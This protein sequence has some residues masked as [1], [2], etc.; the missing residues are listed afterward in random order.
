[1]VWYKNALF[2]EIT[3]KTFAFQVPSGG[4]DR[5]ASFPGLQGQDFTITGI[6]WKES[7]ADIVLSNVGWVSITAGQQADVQITAYTP[8]GVGI[9]LREPALLPTSVTQR[10]IWYYY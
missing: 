10:G 3:V 4:A 1:M 8:N 6:G 7:A 9:V 5:M 2:Q